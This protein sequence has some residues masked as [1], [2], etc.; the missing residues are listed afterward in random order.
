VPCLR[1]LPGQT[2]GLLYETKG[3]ARG[4]LGWGSAARRSAELVLASA[5]LS[6]PPL[7]HIPIALSCYGVHITPEIG[8]RRS[9]RRNARV[10]S[11]ARIRG[12][13]FV[14]FSDQPRLLAN[15]RTKHSIAH[16]SEIHTLCF[17][18]LSFECKMLGDCRSWSRG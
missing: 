12:I 11:A 7:P 9:I 17:A 2:S 14:G 18:S 5:L 1:R 13:S 10:T 3:R 6:L 15:A 16:S 8:Q 4:G